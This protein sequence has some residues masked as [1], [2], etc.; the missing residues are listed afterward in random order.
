MTTVSFQ[1]F[2]ARRFGS[3]DHILSRL[4]SHGY[5]AVE[6]YDDCY[7]DPKILASMLHEN[8]LIM[9]TGHFGLHR[10]EDVRS[11]VD[12]CR[13]VGISTVIGPNIEKANRP[14]TIS[15]WKHM[16]REL[17]SIGR[18][19]VAEGLSFAWHNNDFEFMPARDGT[20][21]M[22]ILLEE[23][24]DTGWQFDVAWAIK[25]GSDPAWWMD[26]YGPRIVSLHLKDIAV[27]GENLDEDG[28]ADVGHG[29]LDWPSLVKSALEKTHASTFVIEHEAVSDLDRFAANSLLAA[30]DWLRNDSSRNSIVSI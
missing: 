6:G 20:L 16:G 9:P 1:L 27:L 8:G 5:K 28:W 3:L 21:P 29:V 15:G 14:D 4:A 30:R 2:T 7:A 22:Q 19:I 17:A 24:P 26:R 11:V 12:V 18:A 10:L 25:G 13:Q 23:T